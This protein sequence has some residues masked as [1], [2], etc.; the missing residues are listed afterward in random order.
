MDRIGEQL[1]AKSRPGFDRRGPR[2]RKSGARVGLKSSVRVGL[3]SGARVGLKSG[4]RVGL[5]RGARV[6]PKEAARAVGGGSVA[7]DRASVEVC[8]HPPGGEPP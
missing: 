7:S 6:G 5:K 3:K 2:R 4:A 8:V 1:I